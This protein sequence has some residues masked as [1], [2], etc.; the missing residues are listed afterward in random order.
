[1]LSEPTSSIKVEL[2]G[3]F[4]LCSFI[5]SALLFIG[6]PCN[7]TIVL[8]YMSDLVDLESQATT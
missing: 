2:F 1:M 6:P 5:S 8:H 4:I 7:V 3:Y